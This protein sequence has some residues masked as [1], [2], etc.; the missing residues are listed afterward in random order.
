M[1][2]IRTRRP[3]TEST[4]DEYNLWILAASKGFREMEGFLRKHCER[5]IYRNIANEGIWKLRDDCQISSEIIDQLVKTAASA[6]L[7]RMQ[8]QAR[9]PVAYWH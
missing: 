2:E 7:Q 6:H 8:Q 9:D 3:P 4:P 1:E 5:R